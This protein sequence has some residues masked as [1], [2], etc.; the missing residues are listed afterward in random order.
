M[1]LE[2]LEVRQLL[3]GPEQQDAEDSCAPHLICQC[4]PPESSNFVVSIVGG[5]IEY[6]ILGVGGGLYSGFKAVRGTLKGVEDSF[7]ELSVIEKISF[8]TNAAAGVAALGFDCYYVF[9]KHR[10]DALTLGTPFA[11]PVLTISL[12]TNILQALL[13]LSFRSAI[14]ESIIGSAA[15]MAFTSAMGAVGYYLYGVAM[16]PRH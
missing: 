12:T 4:P 9:F 16:D 10:S 2:F 13:G 15:G 8:M 11:I 1:N 3:A 14:G 6:G 5:F 7:K